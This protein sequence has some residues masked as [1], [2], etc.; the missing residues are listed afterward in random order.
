[1]KYIL[2]IFISFLLYNILDHYY[3]LCLFL[4]YYFN[5]YLYFY[6]NSL[7]LL[8]KM[9]KRDDLLFYS[10]IVPAK[11]EEDNI[12][13]TIQNIQQIDYNKDYYEV[14]IINDNSTDNTLE[15][16]Q[17]LKLPKNFKIINRE[18]TKGYVS[19]VLNDGINNIS[20]KSDIVGIIDSDCL[21]SNNI[22]KVLNNYFTKEIDGIQCQEWHY[23]NSFNNLTKSQHITCIYENYQN[24]KHNNFKVGHF[25]RSKIFDKNKI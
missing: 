21:A 20:N 19:G 15:L 4:Y 7:K 14:I 22:L 3:N 16:L 6:E 13:K 2:N 23:N 1:M 12:L 18:R 10:L 25:Y 17:N 8:K 5:F 9:G 11:N 24:L